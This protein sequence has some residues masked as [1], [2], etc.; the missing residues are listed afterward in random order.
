MLDIILNGSAIDRRNFCLNTGT[1]MDFATGT[2]YQGLNGKYYLNGG[3]SIISSIIGKAETFKSTI[4]LSYFAKVLNNYPCI[5]GVCYDT[6]FSIP[7][8]MRINSLNNN[9]EDYS[10]RIYLCDKSTFNMIEFYDFI[11]GIAEEKKKKRKSLLVETPF[12]NKKTGKP[13]VSIFPTIV[14]IDSWT[15]MQS[16]QEADIYEKGG[17][18]D[19]KTNT[20]F[21]VDGNKKTQMMRQLPRIAFDAGIYFIPTAHIGGNINMNP[22]APVN[23]DLVNMKASDSIKGAGSQFTFLS[24]N[25]LETRKCKV[26]QDSN[27]KCLFPGRVSSNMELTEV[28][29]M[30]DKC[31]NNQS[32]NMFPH[33]VSKTFGIQ[34]TLDYYSL[35][36]D[37][38]MFGLDGKTEQ[39]CIM[40]PKVVFSRK[41]IRDIIVDDY[42]FA[43][44]LEL[45]GQLC[46]I[47][48]FWTIDKKVKTLTAKR[49]IDLINKSKKFD[50]QEVLNTEGTWSFNKTKRDRKYLSIFDILTTIL[51]L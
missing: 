3:L 6:E 13:Y 32:G 33:V 16:S 25:V 37:F 50:M 20:A 38:N 26:L 12:I 48:Y 41:T 49:F 11:K 51:E 47:K 35:L 15:L 14:C 10:D 8:V 24:S 34:Q 45:L 40:K 46:Y 9:I 44:G 42:E 1:I 21:M 31:K 39:T 28:M 27:K 43:R 36:K 22:Y 19:S 2:F 7:D 18:G 5:D 17:L 29:L 30:V 23:K 4:A